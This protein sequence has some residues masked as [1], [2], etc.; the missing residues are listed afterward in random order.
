MNHELIQAT[1]L[2]Q[3]QQQPGLGFYFIEIIQLQ[4]I[5]LVILLSLIN[6]DRLIHLADQEA[7]TSRKEAQKINEKKLLSFMRKTLIF[8]I[9]LIF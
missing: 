6:M 9:I 7:S 4:V 2:H 1:Q 5:L 8:G 3:Q